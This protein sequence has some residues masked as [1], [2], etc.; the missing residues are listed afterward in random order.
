MMK[1]I[2]TTM[3]FLKA[4]TMS[5]E[6]SSAGLHPA[7]LQA[8]CLP[9]LNTEETDWS[10]WQRHQWFNGWG[11]LHAWSKVL[12]WQCGRQWAG[13]G[14]SLCWVRGWRG[15]GGYQLTSGW[16]IGYHGNQQRSTSFTSPFDKLSW[17]RC[18]DLQIRTITSW[19]LGQ[20]CRHLLIR[21]ND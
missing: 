17:W 9:S 21:L 6:L 13:H 11:T 12:E 15:E 4:G 5:T 20:V 10:Q 18:S 19:G 7:G 2:I 8:L 3:S 1:I 14:S 16:V